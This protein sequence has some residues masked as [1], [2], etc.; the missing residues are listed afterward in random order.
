VLALRITANEWRAGYGQLSGKQAEIDFMNWIA[1][2]TTINS[3]E[4]DVRRR[5]R[6]IV[7][8]AL[9]MAGLAVLFVPVTLVQPR[10]MAGLLAIIGTIGVWLGAIALARQ[11]RVTIAGALVT[12]C[13]S[14]AVFSSMA[15][16]SAASGTS[17]YLV[18]SVLLASV[19]LKP[20][21]IWVV[22]GIN[23]FGLGLT[24]VV[25]FGSTLATPQM[26]TVIFGSAVLL[27]M[28]AI[29]SYTAGRG[30]DLALQS[31]RQHAQQAEL[32]HTQAERQTQDLVKQAASLEAAEERLRELVATLETPAVPLAD[33]I[34]LAPI[35]GTLD[36][37]RAQSIATMLLQTVSQQRAQ[38]LILDIGGV[39][40]VDR[41]VAHGLLQVAQSVK[42]LG[43]DVV[44]TGISA[45]VA[46]TLI[47]LDINFDG[48]KTARS[49]QAVLGE[50]VVTD[51]RS[52]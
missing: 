5:G 17:F 22:L 39:A 14:L 46:R 48:L 24:A 36:S 49:A 23:L 40:T 12:G 27:V 6:N 28:T 30:T 42:L 31:A 50:L 21:H 47:E 34:L 1:V 19:M 41:L 32:A 13:V 43:C 11:G 29:I 16:Q 4:E 7:L 51:T 25:V 45:S 52:Q 44:L 9:A 15:N 33:G 10:P 20:K 26:V 35:I 2:L 8:T 37:R 38:L 3:T 18:L